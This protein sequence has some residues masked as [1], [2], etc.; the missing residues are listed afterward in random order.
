MQKLFEE[1]SFFVFE[2]TFLPF[3]LL[4]LPPSLLDM[5]RAASA[6]VAMAAPTNASCE[7]LFGEIVTSCGDWVI[8]R[9]EVVVCTDGLTT[10]TENL[11]LTLVQ[12]A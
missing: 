5:I 10:I 4:G 2:S 8:G 3:M 1:V 12:S 11:G 7:I 9:D 6:T